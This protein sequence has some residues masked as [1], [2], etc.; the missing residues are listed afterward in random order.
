MALGVDAPMYPQSGEAEVQEQTP[1]T[2][3]IDADPGALVDDSGVKVALEEKVQHDVME[4]KNFFSRPVEVYTG[5]WPVGGGV[6]AVINP[7]KIW[8][9]DSRICNRLNNYYLFR[10]NL[11]LKVVMNGN[12]FAWG[13]TMVS[14]CP[15]S[16]Y[17]NAITTDPRYFAT[18]GFPIPFCD[19]MQASQRQ[20]L[21]LDPTT[22]KGGEMVIP[23]HV[24]T[25][26]V[27]LNTFAFDNVGE[28]WICS[29][30]ALQQ[31]GSTKPLTITIY[32][33]CEDAELSV[34]TQVNMLGLAP[35]AG[36]ETRLGPLSKPMDAV[37]KA[38]EALAVV[39]TFSKWAFPLSHVMKLGASV[40]SAFGFGRPLSQEPV[41]RVFLS[42]GHNLSSGDALDNAFKLSLDSNDEVCVDPSLYGFGSEDVLA[43]K[44]LASIPSLVHTAAWNPDDLRSDVLVSFPVTP[45][46]H[47][48]GTR[49][50][51]AS[52]YWQF[53]PAGMVAGQFR[54]WRGTMRV[55]MQIV[56]NSFHRGKLLVVW[57]PVGTSSGPEE[58]VQRS[59][60]VDIAE[61]RDFTF[62][63]GWGGLFP[64]LANPAS[65]DTS[66]ILAN[67]RPTT[68]VLTPSRGSSNGVVTVY[69][70]NPLVSS[71]TST[72]PI[73]V[74]VWCSF[75]DLQVAVPG[76]ESFRNFAIYPNVPTPTMQA[77]SGSVHLLKTDIFQQE[78]TP[79]AQL[80][81]PVPTEQVYGNVTGDVVLSLRKLLHRYHRV[82]GRLWT[83]A[84]SANT[85]LSARFV[86]SVCPNHY[87]P[88]YTGF[89]STG[90][91]TTQ[92][93]EVSLNPLTFTTSC[94]AFWRGGM[95]M[96]LTQVTG[97]TFGYGTVSRGNPFSIVNTVSSLSYPIANLDDCLRTDDNTSS[98]A[99]GFGNSGINMLEIPYGNPSKF[100]S[101][102]PPTGP[103]QT[104]M[105][106]V[107]DFVNASIGATTASQAYLK[108][109]AAAEDFNVF[110]FRGVPSLYTFSPP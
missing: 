45:L 81:P 58:Q 97:A 49:P 43:V 94:F 69:V 89:G 6:N 60:I 12:P 50:L 38:A 73:E 20:H 3:F 108:W 8:S 37:A 76:M 67:L 78:Q 103:V 85:T 95:R 98:G 55:R 93:N 42:L 56:A 104:E 54:Y 107:Y 13:C 96:T 66:G 48:A 29:T 15:N 70:Q 2:K 102:A 72:L 80:M 18:S 22:S 9:Q 7:W 61:C 90:S 74:N 16:N 25:S 4:I 21:L 84:Q 52:Q 79:V 30:N 28:L 106:I 109:L 110:Y 53:M 14:Y 68:S 100:L 101:L 99:T 51:V 33:W 59:L 41:K 23:L 75:P 88:G 11:T 62:D 44:S 24:H 10:G 92:R 91:G 86:E 46:L 39:P 1:T 26:G 34:P 105:S 64:M 35:Q 40:A 31:I 82:G 87:C 65:P 77:Q 17:P 63:I 19:L 32:A 71:Q 83:A 57:D 36:S 47:K 27:T 5:S